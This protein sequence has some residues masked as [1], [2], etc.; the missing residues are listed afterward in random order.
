MNSALGKTGGFLLRPSCE[1]ISFKSADTL[2]K[3]SSGEFRQIFV[4]IR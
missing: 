4:A 1:Y 2:E 3:I